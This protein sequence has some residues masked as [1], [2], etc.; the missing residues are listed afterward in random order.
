MFNG[1]NL[2][3]NHDFDNYLKKFG[4][5]FKNDD[6]EFGGYTILKN[7]KT[8]LIIDSGS[9]PEYKFSKDYQSG[10]LSF[11]IISN[12]KKLITNCGY[13]KKNIKLNKLSKSSAAQS[14]LIIDDNSSCKFIKI[15]KSLMLKKS[16]KILKK[17]IVFEKDYW[18]VN[19]SHDGYLKKYNSIHERQI[20]FYPNKM[21]FI[22]VDKIIKKKTNHNFKFD[23]RF[24]L[25]PSVK[26]MKTQD[27][28]TILIELED[29]GWKFT[30]DNYDINI[31]NGLYFGEKEQISD[32]LSVIPLITNSPSEAELLTLSEAYR[33]RLVEIEETGKVNR[34]TIRNLSNKALLLT[35]G[36]ILEGA[37]QNRTL[38]DSTLLP[39]NG[40]F[41]I[42]VSCVEQNRW[43]ANYGEFTP[44]NDHHNFIA[45]GN[46]MNEVNRSKL[47][48]G[49]KHAN[50]SNIWRDVQAKQEKLN[51]HSRTQSIN[52][53]YRSVHSELRDYSRKIRNVP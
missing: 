7:K 33:D 29:E 9:S 13:Y 53:S 50:Q 19:F 41:D 26:L 51:V 6:Q 47:E 38:N 39:S 35:N 12:G 20:E 10:A 45:K 16:I 40:Q 46:K 49:T 36:D 27:N 15:D 43:S 21:T 25:E 5:K 8:C 30:C 34:V 14:T 17:K 23:I 31:D 28:K 52:D 32:T 3:N 18:K 24:H 44:S 37:K 4:Y 2:S 11:E 42:D 22:G 1:N 48:T